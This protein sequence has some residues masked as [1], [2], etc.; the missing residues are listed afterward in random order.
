[1]SLKSRR[2]LRLILLSISVI[3]FTFIAIFLILDKLNNF[4]LSVYNFIIK[5]KS[6][7]LTG[8]FKLITFFASTEW[9]ICLLLGILIIN[10]FSKISIM[11]LIYVGIIALINIV[12]KNIFL[13]IRPLDLM[14][15][16]ETG[17]SFPSGHSTMSLALY[18]LVAY[19]VYKS[20]YQK[21]IKVLLISLLFLLSFLIGL[22]RIYLGVHYASD[23]LAGFMLAICYFCIF[24][25]IYKIGKE[26]QK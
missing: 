8:F 25:N 13:R 16:N 20:N 3:I 23:V 18:G 17:Y 11:L 26:V 14:I 24:T 1:M 4:D 22:S 2:I 5:Y 6:N 15:I 7:F 21:N 19:L 10:K 12:L 9:L